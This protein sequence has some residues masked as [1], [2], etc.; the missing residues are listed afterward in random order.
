MD[1]KREN[2]SAMTYIAWDDRVARELGIPYHN[3]EMTHFEE[4]A[5]RGFVGKEGKF[6]AVNMS[7]E[8]RER[9]SG[10]CTG[11]AFRA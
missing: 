4:L 8:E 5:S 11:A 9:L 7:E 10:L 3:V 6:E 2:V 1:T